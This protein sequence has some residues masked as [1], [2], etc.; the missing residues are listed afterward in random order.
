MSEDIIYICPM[1][2]EVCQSRPGS[3]RICGMALEPL[4]AIVKNINKIFLEEY[5]LGYGRIYLRI[6]LDLPQKGSSLHL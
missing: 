3:C 4:M 2:S 6:N 1:H 5:L